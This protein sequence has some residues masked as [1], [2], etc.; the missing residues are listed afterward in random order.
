[1]T[2]R[3][4]G[5]Q[6]RPNRALSKSLYVS[7]V[8]DKSKPNEL[9]TFRVDECIQQNLISDCMNCPR[10]GQL[11][12]IHLAPDIVSTYKSEYACNVFLCQCL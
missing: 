12:I 10:H 8:A 9:Y 11:E 3:R 6:N 1:M 7:S 2:G 4:S 5:I